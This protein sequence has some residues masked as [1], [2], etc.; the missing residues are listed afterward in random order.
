[1]WLFAAAQT[2]DFPPRFAKSIRFNIA[3]ISKHNNHNGV[4]NDRCTTTDTHTLTP[5]TILVHQ[6]NQ[7]L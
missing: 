4:N 1:M 7:Q 2:E 5:P 3:L 6:N